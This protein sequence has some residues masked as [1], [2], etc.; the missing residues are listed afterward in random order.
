MLQKDY[1]ASDIERHY[2]PLTISPQ[3]GKKHSVS[4]EIDETLTVSARG[5]KQP[6]SVPLD[7]Y[8]DEWI[9]RP[10]R[11]HLSLLGEFGTGKTWFCRRLANRLA[12]AGGRIPILIFLR[13][14]SRAYDIRQLITDALVNRYQVGL[15]AGFE[16]FQYLNEEGRL[17]LIFDGFDEMERRVADYR[18]AV[19]NFWEIAKLVLPRSKVILTCRTAFFRHQMEEETTLRLEGGSMRIV[20]GEEVIELH[21]RT[22]YEVVHLERFNEMQIR[23][24]LERRAPYKAESLFTRISALSNIWDLAQRPVLLDLIVRTLPR[25]AEGEVLNLATLYEFYTRE[26][27][28]VRSGLIGEIAPEDRLFFVREL[29][30]EMQQT[31][32]FRIPFSEFPDRVT[33]HFNLKKNPERIAFFERDIRTQSYLERDAAGTYGFSHKSFLEFFIAKKLAPL[34]I[35]AEPVSLGLTEPI[36]SF[37]HYLLAGEDFYRTRIEDD[38]AF[39]PPGP[40]I[41]GS[42]QQG[43]LILANV[44]NAFWIDRFPVTNAQFC[45]FLNVRGNCVDGGVAWI[46][47]ETA[48]IS[49]KL[50]LYV[51]PVN[52]ANHPVVS[53]NMFGAKAY[54]EWVGKRLPTELE[55]EKAARGVDGREYPWG[56]KFEAFRCNTHEAGLGAGIGAT[57]PDGHYGEKGRSPFGCDD[58]AGNVLEW[59]VAGGG[60]DG[61]E[62]ALRGGS[63]LNSPSDARCSRRRT[64]SALEHKVSFG[65]RCVRSA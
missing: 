51:A 62:P 13:D 16:T 36:V 44:E 31:S 53:V 18:T 14:Y 24:A 17:L 8:I 43:N 46:D 12:N 37:V 33:T 4:P 38:M 6:S 29:A 49:R 48:R 1:A 3:R 15:A 60:D 42:E 22:Q 11:N 58:F 59:T 5:D 32:R 25:I 50:Q 39:V 61:Q 21:D 63:W 23:E 28:E 40:F 7:S 19:E 35:G 45:R 10:D 2:V 57:T 34:L 52:Q 64:A 20:S 27:L 47:L 54:A 55:W 9:A 56:E 65:F 41:Y 30:W 26:L